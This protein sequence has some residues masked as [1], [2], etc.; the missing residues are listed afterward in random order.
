MRHGKGKGNRRKTKNIHLAQL[1][2]SSCGPRRPLCDL[3]RRAKKFLGLHSTSRQSFTFGSNGNLQLEVGLVFLFLLFS[4]FPFFF[5]VFGDLATAA[6]V[7][8]VWQLEHCKVI[9]KSRIFNCL[10]HLRVV[11]ISLDLARNIY[12][13]LSV[14]QLL[15]LP[16]SLV[17]P[18]CL[19]GLST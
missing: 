9:V 10:H 5:F 18:C 15:H 7:D 14:C 6:I 16:V 3:Y 8:I 13:L 4:I 11:E 12:L 1:W 17:L 19:P 2:F